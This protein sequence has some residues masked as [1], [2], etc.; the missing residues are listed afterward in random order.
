MATDVLD[1]L[2]HEGMSSDYT[3]SGSDADADGRP[4]LLTRVPH[5]RRR[6][7]SSLFDDLD[8]KGTELKK[9]NSNALGKRF[10]QRGR[11]SVRTQIKSTRCVTLNLPRSCYHS[12]F[13]AGLNPTSLEEVAPVDQTIPHFEHWA[14]SHGT[15]DSE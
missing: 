10:V 13:L 3:D 7:I 1:V 2:G 4:P 8:R 15:S 12:K 6:I 11:I 5:Y 9:R 14:A